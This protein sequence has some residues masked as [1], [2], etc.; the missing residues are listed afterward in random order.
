MREHHERL[1]EA[2]GMDNGLLE[3]NGGSGKRLQDIEAS[4]M[5][6]PERVPVKGVLRRSRRP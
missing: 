2:P 4:V 3:G 1:P 5:Y 6:I